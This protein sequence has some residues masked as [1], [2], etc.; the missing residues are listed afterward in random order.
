[1]KKTVDVIAKYDRL[2][3]GFSRHD[4]GD[5][6]R[7]FRR[8]AR[9]VIENG[10]PLRAGDTVL[11]L[12]CGDGAAAVPLLA[13]GIEY[14]GVDASSQ[15]VA[16]TRA[17][18][19]DR[20]RVEQGEIETYTPPERVTAT[21]C[22]RAVYYADD[23]VR[24]FAHVA[25]YTERKFVFD[26]TPK[27]FDER[28]IVADLHAGGFDRV[29]LKPF[30]YPQHYAPPGALDTLLRAA[31]RAGPLV[32]PLLRFRFTY[33]VAASCGDDAVTTTAPASASG[34]TPP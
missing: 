18:L 28:Q 20:A 3:P 19:G 11:D 21:T 30:L 7:Y 26:F 34:R 2:A 1:V 10:P 24:F 32:R 31:E 13:A 6:E 23:L 29:E 5:P 14:L 12:G 33:I 4:Y 22:F 9:A 16:Q 15:M 27:D 17:L 8:R 25:G